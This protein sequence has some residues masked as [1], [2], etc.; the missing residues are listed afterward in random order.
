MRKIEVTSKLT[1]L[2]PLDK[3]DHEA[4]E[5][6]IAAGYPAVESVLPSLLEWMQDINWPVAQTLAPFLASIGEP[7]IPHLKTI[8][9][10]D[11]EIWKAWIISE[12]VR[13][14]SPLA[15]AFREYLERVADHPTPD[16]D[17]EYVSDIASEVLKRHGWR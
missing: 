16:E 17:G 8:F 11:D 13:E 4:A 15:K 2:V 14:S 5:R 9:E 10:T 6:A 1:G 3:H 12:I 7:L